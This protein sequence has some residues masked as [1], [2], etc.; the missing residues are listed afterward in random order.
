M[1]VVSKLAGRLVNFAFWLFYLISIL[2]FNQSHHQQLYGKV[3]N[4][5]ISV[6]NGM[7]KGWNPELSD[8]ILD[9]QEALRSHCLRF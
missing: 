6:L 5:N 3:S 4:T 1:V 8:S 2:V 9:N 7:V